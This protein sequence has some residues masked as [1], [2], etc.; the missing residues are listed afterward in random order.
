[1]DK[2]NLIMAVLLVVLCAGLILI[3]CFVNKYT[4]IREKNMYNDLEYAPSEKYM[5]I[6][7]NYYDTRTCY[8]IV[9]KYMQINIK[10]ILNE[11]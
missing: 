10:K 3:V 4:Q 7:E 11:D 8:N 9:S 5:E 2:T 6:C 1:M